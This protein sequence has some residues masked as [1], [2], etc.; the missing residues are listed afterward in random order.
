MT[1]YPQAYSG[2]LAET[3]KSGFSMPS[4]KDTCQFLRTLAA[5]KPSGSFLELGTGTGLSTAWIL[6]GM[7]H[8]STLLSVDNDNSYLSI[9]GKHLGHDSRVT[10][11]ETDAGKW[12]EENQ[13]LDF[14]FI[15]A[16]TWH[17]KY[18]ML[19]ETLNM[20]KPGGLYIVDDLL[21]QKNWPEGHEQKASAF[22]NCLK[23]KTTLASVQLDWATGIMLGVRKA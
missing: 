6:E 13:H 23:E 5:S 20:L 16:D 21:P 1:V 22:I 15:F 2:I 19:E 10:F 14:D 9:A 3:T 12:I 4:E 8:S 11:I 7:D 17:G 18:L